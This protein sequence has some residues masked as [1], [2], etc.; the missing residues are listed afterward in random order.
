MSRRV[1]KH[2]H[3]PKEHDALLALGTTSAERC[4]VHRM[5][6]RT[7]FHF[8]LEH[9]LQQE[10]VWRIVIQCKREA[11]VHLAHGRAHRK[12]KFV[13]PVVVF[14]TD[15]CKRIEG[16]ENVVEYLKTTTIPFDTYDDI[17]EVH[18]MH[19]LKQVQ[20]ASLLECTDVEL[21]QST[22]K[23]PHTAKEMHHHLCGNISIKLKS[24]GTLYIKS[25]KVILMFD[26]P[27]L[28]NKHYK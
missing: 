24:E 8:A 18:N 14:E 23:D 22:G 1:I 6:E 12:I 19:A 9:Q 5:T 11:E 10:E 16:N 25:H 21:K 7:P 28:S 26:L 27:E 2:V 4:I 3:D 15:D 20:I 17:Q 13:S